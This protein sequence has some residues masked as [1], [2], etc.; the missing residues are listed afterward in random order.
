MVFGATFRLRVVWLDPR[1]EYLNL[2][3][4]YNGTLTLKLKLRY[5]SRSLLPTFWILKRRAFFGNQAI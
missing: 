1:L 2:V 3:C 4:K 5:H